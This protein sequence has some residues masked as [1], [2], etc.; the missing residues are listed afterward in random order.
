MTIKTKWALLTILSLLLISW[1]ASF[2]QSPQ[3][4]TD[5]YHI[6]GTV[7]G[8]G[9]HLEGFRK[10]AAS[11]K[12]TGLYPLN[13]LSM[14]SDDTYRMGDRGKMFLLWFDSLFKPDHWT[15]TRA[16]GL[17]FI[18][19]LLVFFISFWIQGFPAFAILATVFIGS[20]SFQLYETYSN[21]NIFCWQL[22]L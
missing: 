2:F 21:V 12:A 17:F 16:N 13:G 15:Y 6:Y 10:F 20:C 14:E 22:I 18:F 7:G 9:H 5:K 4:I 19:A 11:Y 8:G 3:L 1:Q